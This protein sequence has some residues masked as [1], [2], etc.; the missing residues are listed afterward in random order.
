MDIYSKTF[1]FITLKDHKETFLNNSTA[2]L[3]NPVKTS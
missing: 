2:Q 3:I 1:G